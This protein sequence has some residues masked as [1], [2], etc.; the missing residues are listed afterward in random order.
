VVW[1][2]YPT[3]S[4]KWAIYGQW[5][6][7]EGE[8]KGESFRISIQEYSQELPDVGYSNSAKKYLVVWS[9]EGNIYGQLV[10]PGP[11]PT[12]T[13]TPMPP[14]VKFDR[15]RYYTISDTAA[16]TVEDPNR[17]CDPDEREVIGVK[18][19][20]DSCPKG[21]YIRLKEENADSSVFT[22]LD[23]GT[24]LRFSTNTCYSD[25]IK[26]TNEETIR[27]EYERVDDL[28][29]IDEATWYEVAPTPT[30]TCIAIWMSIVE[31]PRPTKMVF[32][33][34][35]PTATPTAMPSRGG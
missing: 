6:S 35:T 22:C 30:P 25:T 4:Y 1:Q 17:S 33:T 16:I 28:T 14:F 13:P 27:V 18:V 24:C 15:E 29:E 21:V 32:P 8:L 26:V 10:G 5:I 19:V 11:T 9:H 3:E 23:N 20:S 12:M 7:R 2:G 34:P 31:T